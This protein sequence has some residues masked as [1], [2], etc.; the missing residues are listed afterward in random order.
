MKIVLALTL[1]V[2]MWLITTPAYSGCQKSMGLNSNVRK[3]KDCKDDY[4]NNPDAAQGR[5]NIWYK[6]CECMYDNPCAANGGKADCQQK[7]NWETTKLG[8]THWRDYKCSCDVAGFELDS[9]GKTCTKD[10]CAA[11]GGRGE[12]QGQC[13]S[14][15]DGVTTCTCPAGYS[16]DENEKTCS[17]PRPLSDCHCKGRKANFGQSIN[18]DVAQ[19]DKSFSKTDTAAQCQEK[20]KSTDG[21]VLFNWWGKKPNGD[22]GNSY[23]YCYLKKKGPYR[24]TAT[25]EE[26]TSGGKDSIEC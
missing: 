16:L 20:C 19:A 7:C 9:N 2:A 25:D 10:G 13:S 6:H 5:C 24:D 26:V 18:Q 17:C 21:C 4:G 8:T 1:L 3:C 12:C 15:K 22:E 11:N 23:K 14:T